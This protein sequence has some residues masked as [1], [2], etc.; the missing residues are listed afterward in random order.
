M[1]K[2]CFLLL[3]LF[4]CLSYAKAPLQHLTVI[5]DWFPNPDHAPL[6]I[7]KQ[8]GFFKEQGLDVELIGPADPNDPPKWLA[9]NKA[10]IGLTY[11]PEF[12]QQIDHGLPLTRIGTLI[13]KPLNCVLALETSG[14]KTPADLRGRKIGL[15]DSGLSNTML[16]VMLEKQGLTTQDV[17]IINVH[18]NLMQALLSHQVDAVTGLMRNVEI[19]QLE[20]M[21]QKVVAFFPEK[22]DI[23]NYSELIFIANRKHRNDPRV[24]RFMAALKKAVVYLDQHREETWQQ[25]AKTYPEENNAVNHATWFATIP[26]FAK[27]PAIIDKEQCARFADFMQ[28]RKLIKNK[29]TV[30]EYSC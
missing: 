27:E 7:A 2:F 23:P 21:H 10:D 29:E 25:F 5:L 18:Y 11:E 12:M 3:A 26:Y 8:Q 6:V 1:R 14:I 13:N 24:P 9:A 15:T 16:Q 30:K 19:P 4:S 22:Y 17:E 20:S 28:E